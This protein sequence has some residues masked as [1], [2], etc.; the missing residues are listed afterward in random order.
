MSLRVA[1]YLALAVAVVNG[2]A[3][4]AYALILPAMRESLGWDYAAAGWLNTANSLGY[5]VGGLSGLLLL[6]KIKPSK[7]FITGLISTVCCIALVGVTTNLYAMLVWRFLAG[8]GSAWVFACGGALVAAYYRQSGAA[9]AVFFAGGGLGIALSGLAVFP[10]LTGAMTWPQAWLTLGLA[11][12]LLAVMPVLTVLRTQPETAQANR[13]ETPLAANWQRRFAAQHRWIIAAY[14][15]FG[16]GYIVYMTFVIAWL[17]QMRLSDVFSAS[18]WVLMGIAA[19]ASGWVWRIPLGSWHPA[20]TFAA[21]T[22]CTALGS[23]IPIVMRQPVALMLS[24]VL[25]GGSFF[26]VPAAM[27]ALAKQSL[28]QLGWAPAMNFF[29]MIFAVGQALGPVLAGFTADT[30]GLNAAMF[31]GA[32]VLLLSAGLALV[33]PRKSAAS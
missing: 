29:T 14:F 32:G 24:T 10:V 33:Q 19:M 18:L 2:F 20:K 9:I 21:A 30:Y 23:A 4:F 1:L 15:C 12:A 17:K 31:L 11:G 16:V 7:L 27:T 28:P 6:S 8:V 25:V 13:P 26:M 5:A 22:L 3:R